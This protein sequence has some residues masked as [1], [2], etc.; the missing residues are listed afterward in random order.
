MCV[1]PCELIICLTWPIQKVSP[2]E[3]LSNEVSPTEVSPYLVTPN[4]V[5]Q[6]KFEQIKVLP[7]IKS[8]FA[9]PCPQPELDFQ[10]VMISRNTLASNSSE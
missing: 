4:G 2:N 10:L 3:I 5:S 7:T 9:N 1:R 8:V 6:M